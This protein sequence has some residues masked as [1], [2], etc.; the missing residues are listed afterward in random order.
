MKA[1]AN[2]DDE[3]FWHPSQ[4]CQNG[5][6]LLANETASR[7]TLNSQKSKPPPPLPPLHPPLGAT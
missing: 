3:T 1:F 7:Q 4:N 6:M 5:W 2:Y